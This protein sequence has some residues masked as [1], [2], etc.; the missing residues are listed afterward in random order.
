MSLVVFSLVHLS[1]IT[2][3]LTTGRHFVTMYVVV[4]YGFISS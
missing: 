1:P 3:F 2:F 4:S